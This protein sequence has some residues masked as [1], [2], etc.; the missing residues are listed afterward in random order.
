MLATNPLN[1][2]L[3]LRNISLGVD[4]K[5]AVS[6]NTIDEIALDAYESRFV[7]I[8]VTANKS[9]ALSFESVTFLFHG[10]LPYTQ[11]LR[12]R[13]K[14]LAATK[15]Q[16]IRPTYGEDRS[17]RVSISEAMPCL[18]AEM[19]D[20]PSE[21]YEGEEVQVTLTLRNTGSLPVRDIALS[22]S[23]R[24]W[25]RVPSIAGMSFCPAR[26]DM[27]LISLF[28]RVQQ[29]MEQY[30]AAIGITINTRWD[31]TTWRREG[32]RPS[33]DWGWHR[34]HRAPRTGAVQ[35]YGRRRRDDERY[36]HAA[37]G[38]RDA[39]GWYQSSS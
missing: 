9:G 37:C 31:V 34:H 4:Q 20:W 39:R 35:R 25:L 18:S 12:R 2:P 3:I 22:V 24:G 1:A 15:E 10:F 23:E 32:H 30:D 28:R 6:V 36:K 14:R 29:G 27:T 17:L 38:Q 7:T 16:R 26:C 19:L 8:D 11:P 13:G 33:V 5:D 21:L